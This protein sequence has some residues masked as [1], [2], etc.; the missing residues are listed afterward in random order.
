MKRH[1]TFR[2]VVFS[3]MISGF[4]GL[5]QGTAELYWLDEQRSREMINFDTASM[6]LRSRNGNTPETLIDH[7]INGALEFADVLVIG[8]GDKIGIKKS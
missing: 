8:F 4:R 6:I 3:R 5:N 2:A 1:G 7:R